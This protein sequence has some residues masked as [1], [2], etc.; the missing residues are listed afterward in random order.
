MAWCEFYFIDHLHYSTTS[1]HTYWHRYHEPTNNG[2]SESRSKISIY[3]YKQRKNKITAHVWMM[4]RKFI[5]SNFNIK[6]KSAAVG[7]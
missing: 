2:L 1:P 5:I 4:S 6:K 3:G 7:N